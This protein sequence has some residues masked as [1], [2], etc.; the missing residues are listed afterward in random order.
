MSNDLNKVQLIG[1]LGKDPEIRYTAT[2]AAI[3][4]ITLAT[5]ESWK[6]KQGQK[7]EKA[8][9]HRIVVFGKLAEIVSE[10]LKKGALVYFEGKLQTR[11]WQDNSGVDKYTTE[12]VVDGFNGSMQ[13]LGGRGDNNATQAAQQQPANQAQ[14]GGQQQQAPAQTTAPDQTGGF[15]DFDDDIPF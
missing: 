15:E 3:A 13:M 5:G 12:I 7:Q 14:G 9:W 10:Y 1:R 6:D 2:G 4:N 8:E 11:K